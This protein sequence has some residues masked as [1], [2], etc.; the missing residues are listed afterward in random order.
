[1]PWALFNRP[2]IQLGTLK[3]YIEN[4]SHDISVTT[5]HPYL[6]IAAILG[7]DLYHWISQNPWVSEAIYSPLVF[8]EQTSSAE[9]LAA[10][11]AR[12]A[13]PGI[14]RSF[15]YKSLFRKVEKHLR[16]WCK[17]YDWSQYSLVG[18]SVCFHQLFATLAAAKA[19]KKKFPQTTIV[20]GGSSC[21]GATGRSLLDTFRFIDYIIP[22]EGERGLLSLCAYISEQKNGVLPTNVITRQN[23]KK[24]GLELTRQVNDMQLA[25]LKDLPVP[26][27]DDYFSELKKLFGSKPFIPVL[28]VEFSRGCWWNKCTFC[29][30]N[31]QWC[32][33][34]FKKAAQMTHEVNSLASRYKC[35]DLTFVDNMLPPKEALQFFRK[36]SANSVDLQFFAEIRSAKSKKNPADIFCEYHRGGLTTIQVG[37][38]AFSNSLLKKM[39]KG[40]SVIENITT[41][42]SAQENKLK[43]EGNLILQ[44]P[45]SSEAEV[46]ETLDAL[47]FV[48]PYSPLAPATFFLGHDSP[49]HND[50]QKFGIK[51][52][53]NHPNNYKL[54]PRKILSR[55]DLLVKD[56]RGDRIKQRKIWKPILQKVKQWQ[57]YHTNRKQDALKKPLLYYRDG[58]SFLLIRQELPDGRILRHR[59]E[60]TSRLIYLACTQIAIDKELFEKFSD[61]PPEKILL[62]LTDLQK[63]KILFSEK[64]NYLSLAVHFKD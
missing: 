35:L 17:S 40:V 32:G 1:M 34:R 20:L 55:L 22:G 36:T 31:L 2:S 24:D 3:A 15:N 50:P 51:A 43:L 37:I 26:N 29:N 54:F 9:K 33:Y 53:V 42:R 21:A 25:T 27:Y 39:Q 23:R 12:Q 61:F 6:E 64:N 28:P 7:P 49:V 19:I 48:F 41:M 30:L 56:Y 10:K 38:E 60:G 5:S 52:I 58:G 46:A 59:L 14:K 62:F 18:F 45:G 8:P 63:K 57:Q 16:E 13:D 4:K 47:D 11:Y 44:F